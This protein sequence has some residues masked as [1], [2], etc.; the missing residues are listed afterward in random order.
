M[1][2]RY[3]RLLPAVASVALLL[4]SCRPSAEVFED[5]RR[6]S[7][8]GARVEAVRYYERA[9]QQDPEN[10][11]YRI[12]LYRA[13]LAASYALV[14][15]ARKKRAADDLRGAVADYETA[16]TLDPS[17]RYVR[18][19]LSELRR[20]LEEPAP[21]SEL[22]REKERLPLGAP[23]RLDPD[24]SEPLR[25]R[26]SEGSL[27]E[28][29]EALARLAGVNILFD[30]S[31]RDVDVEVDLDGVTFWQA[32]DLLTRTNGLFYKVVDSSTV[33]LSSERN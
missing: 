5:A 32:L 18:E 7:S 29:L 23:P 30:E 8:P 28:T 24:S 22:V 26:F 15:E 31:F 13:R 12:A 20:K 11:E 14:S 17:N 9:V 25:L 16:L 3:V 19:E 21:P 1:M 2:A 27:K 10:L 33:R 6:L 4:A